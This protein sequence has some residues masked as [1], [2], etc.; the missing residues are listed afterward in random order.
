M[1]Q[2]LITIAMLIPM[3]GC[4]QRYYAP[5]E[6]DA[7]WRVWDSAETFNWLLENGQK[8]DVSINPLITYTNDYGGS[9]SI[10][11]VTEA[12]ICFLRSNK[13]LA[14]TFSESQGIRMYTEKYVYKLSDTYSAINSLIK[15]FW[16]DID[17]ENIIYSPLLDWL[18][19]PCG[20]NEYSGYNAIAINFSNE[21]G[22]ND[23]Y[24]DFTSGENDIKYYNLQ[25]MS[26]DNAEKGQIIIRKD[27]SKTI[28]YINH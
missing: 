13:L 17:F 23:V 12:S 24:S 27:G 21:S 25:G 15:Q 11:S 2:I 19:I 20:Y 9:T 6:I 1:K 10:S 26:V 22:I 4:A 16:F 14:M 8:I 3:F 28:K 18:L 7:M 5:S